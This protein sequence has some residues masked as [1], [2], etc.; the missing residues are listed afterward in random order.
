[1]LLSPAPRRA[2]VAGDLFHGR[3]PDDAVYVGRAAPGLPASR[4]ANPYPAR[5]H[6]PRDAIQLYRGYLAAHP[7]LARAAIR[8][9]AGRDLAC[10]CP[11]GQP[12]HADV[13]LEITDA[14]NVFPPAAGGGI[15][16]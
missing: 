16:P 13:L 14:R 4:Y 9:L 8:D 1:M 7:E 15:S 12:C 10:W 11:L 2:K 5:I 3:V 6:G